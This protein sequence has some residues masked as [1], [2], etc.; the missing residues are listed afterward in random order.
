MYVSLVLFAIVTLENKFF[1]A[2][3]FLFV[4]L[5]FLESARL[6][7]RD[8]KTIRGGAKKFCQPQTTKCF[9]D[10][11]RCRLLDALVMHINK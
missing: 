9:I 8:T 11:I 6:N 5:V 2:I 4:F 10:P 3:F 7:I 1:F